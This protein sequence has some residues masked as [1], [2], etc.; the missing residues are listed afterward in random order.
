MKQYIP[1][2]Y[3]WQ[4]QRHLDTQVKTILDLGCGRGEFGD[5]FNKEGKYQIT[6]VDIFGPYLK[7][8]RKKGR[9]S[10]LIRKDLKKINFPDKSFDLVVCLQT[11]EHLNKKDGQEL[12][13]K[14]EKLARKKVITSVP[15]GNCEQEQYDE[16]KYQEHRSSWFPEDFSKRNYAIY[17]TGLKVV[18]GS[19]SHMGENI[20]F[21]RVI[22]Y[23]VS[24]LLNP[25]ASVSPGIAAQI[26]AVK[27]VTPN[28]KSNIWTSFRNNMLFSYSWIFR[29][30]LNRQEKV[31]DVGCGD[32]LLMEQI[33]RDGKYRVTGMDLYKPYLKKAQQLNTYEKLIYGDVR[34]LKI[35]PKS[36]DAV[37]SSQVIEHLEKKEALGLIKVM[38][39]IAKNRVIIGTTNGYFP[40]DPLEGKDENP[41]QVHKSGW[42]IKEMKKYGYRVYG[43]GIGYIYKPEGLAHKFP[44]LRPAFYILSYLLSPITYLFPQIS[45]YIVAVK[46]NVR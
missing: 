23:L 2:T 29:H 17:G 34:K 18:Y 36:F 21:G 19:K 31:L 1:F 15:V 9:Y 38:E 6:G 46:E 14:L 43:Q 30:H 33:N 8:C 41:L 42:S 13:K 7:E 20:T 39:K 3:F 35:K 45:A 12:M 40:F 4:I 27:N 22:P 26:I 25:L 28:A 16:N 32:G 10:K 5:I 37:V 11:L 24:F 44:N